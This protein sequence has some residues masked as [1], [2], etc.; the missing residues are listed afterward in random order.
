MDAGGAQQQDGGKGGEEQ[1]AAHGKSQVCRP[2]RSQSNGQRS[3]QSNTGKSGEAMQSAKAGIRQP[4]PCEPRRALTRIRKV[5]GSGNGGRA[6]NG[7]AVA[8]VPSHV[9]VVK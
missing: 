1:I 9:A 7:F 3:D 4:L 6:E 8:H 5:I 2:S